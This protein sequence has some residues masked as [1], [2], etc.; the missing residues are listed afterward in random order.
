MAFCK[1]CGE[2]LDPSDTFCGYCGAKV[3]YSI[4]SENT[5]IQSERKNQKHD[6]ESDA[7]SITPKKEKKQQKAD[8]KE[9][10]KTKKRVGPLIVLLFVFLLI[11][12]PVGTYFTTYLLAV[13]NAKD[14]DF[15]SADKMLICRP[16]TNL[17]DDLL[18]IY[19]DAGLVMK[20]DILDE[21]A[22]KYYSISSYEDSRSRANQCST[23]YA[24]KLVKK[25]KFDD[26]MDWGLK[27]SGYN[28]ELGNDIMLEARYYIAANE[29]ENYSDYNS[30][31][32]L[33][34]KNELQNVYDLGYKD[35]YDTLI[36]SQAVL[37]LYYAKNTYY[38]NAIKT[39]DSI[40]DYNSKTADIYNELAEIVFSHGVTL[41]NDGELK[42]AYDYFDLIY[43][44]SNASSYKAVCNYLNL[45]VTD[46]TG[47]KY[48][49]SA[50]EYDDVPNIASVI[51]K[52]DRLSYRFLIGEWN[53]SGHSYYFNQSRTNDIFLFE[54]NIP[55]I[56]SA[57]NESYFFKG[58]V[59]YLGTC[60]SLANRP[61][62][63]FQIDSY[64]EMSIYSEKDGQTYCFYRQ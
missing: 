35:A 3:E 38:K 58:N 14:K 18:I 62:F 19:V 6:V 54:T 51:F 4:I 53:S 48:I 64:N 57:E 44:Y 29:L 55:F 37:A 56:E 15:K 11:I 30:D 27:V 7:V 25:G 50:F 59:M 1:K 28:T 31:S 39:I 20:D 43:Y 13:K 42:E 46:Y 16:L 24:E 41:F 40:K 61:V 32:I 45:A 21:A 63:T 49:K 22:I 12:A 5:N 26:E 36:E 2:R 33:S 60:Y 8:K 47:A 23:E 17:H 10:K 9:K 52:D 34:I